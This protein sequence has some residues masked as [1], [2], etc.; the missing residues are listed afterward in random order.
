VQWQSG[1]RCD[2]Q[3]L[4]EAS[5]RAGW[6]PQC[7][8]EVARL[9]ATPSVRR[10]R[11]VRQHAPWIGYTISS[12][13]SEPLS[14]RPARANASRNI[15]QCHIAEA[16]VG[17]PESLCAD[18]YTARRCGR[19]TDGWYYYVGSCKPCGTS[20]AV[21]A[22]N[23]AAAIIAFLLGLF[24]LWQLLLD[25]R[26]ASPFVFLMRLMETLAILNRTGLEWPPAARDAFSLAS[27]VNFNTE[28]FRFECSLGHPEPL[29]RVVTALM[30]PIGAALVFILA[31]P[32]IRLVAK[33]R[34]RKHPVQAPLACLELMYTKLRPDAPPAQKHRQLELRPIDA[35]SAASWVEYTRIIAA[36]SAPSILN[37]SSLFR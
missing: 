26:V 25:P 24:I 20:E 9:F 36:V 19:C 7:R 23:V 3:V 18:G 30:F 16:C 8:C 37:L 31:W 6:P 1:T 34:G 5:A 28:I 12:P 32:L 35:L 4:W 11:R 33:V 15:V 17:G 14:L 27:L 29:S 10:V 13:S 21:L 2:S 22:L